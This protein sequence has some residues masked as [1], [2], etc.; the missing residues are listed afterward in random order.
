MVAT[1]SLPEKC[2]AIK[3]FEHQKWKKPSSWTNS[4]DYGDILCQFMGTMDIG[5]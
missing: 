5:Y 2:L 3:K 4:L 1:A